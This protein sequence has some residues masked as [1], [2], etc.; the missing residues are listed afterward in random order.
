MRALLPWICLEMNL[1]ISNAMVSSYNQFDEKTSLKRLQDLYSAR[2]VFLDF[3][4]C[5]ILR[6][7]V[8]ISNFH[9]S[10][11]LKLCSTQLIWALSQLNRAQPGSTGL[12]RA[13]IGILEKMSMNNNKSLFLKRIALRALKN[14]QIFFKLPS[15]R[16]K[17]RWQVTTNL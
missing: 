10:A 9:T 15:L 11:G 4:F 2:P 12:N 5:D 1:K 16:V 17:S 7:S 13:Q 14:F 3:M 8:S 6:C